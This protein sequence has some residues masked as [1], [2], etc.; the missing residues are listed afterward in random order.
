MP[1]S[2]PGLPD[3]QKVLPTGVAINI[4]GVGGSAVRYGA[5][6]LDGINSSAVASIVDQ[7]ALKSEDGTENVAGVVSSLNDAIPPIAAQVSEMGGHDTA[8]GDAHS[9]RTAKTA[10][11]VKVDRVDDVDGVGEVHTPNS[12]GAAIEPIAAQAVA[13]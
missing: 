13:R 12:D 5:Q 11:H 7:L 8:Y 2:S 10:A 6:P 9:E 4:S 1:T 3:K